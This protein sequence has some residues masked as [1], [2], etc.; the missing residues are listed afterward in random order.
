MRRFHWHLVWM[1]A[2][3]FGLVTVL[4]G[5]RSRECARMMACCQAIKQVDGVGNACGSRANSVDNPKT[6]ATILETVGHMFEKR[7]EQP[8][9]ACR[10]EDRGD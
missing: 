6:C 7:D 4:S 10:Y 9:E 5:C 2:L 3:A 8:P 1:A